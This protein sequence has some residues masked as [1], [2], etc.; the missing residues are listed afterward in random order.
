MRKYLEEKN[1]PLV[2]VIVPIYNTEK[3]LSDCVESLLQQTY[4][5][6]EIILVDDGSKDSSGAICDQYSSI[7]PIVKVIHT[8]NQGRTRARITGVEQ[9]S[10]EYVT[11]VDAD[12]FVAPTYVE[13]LTSCLIEQN[14]EI[15]CCECY[16]IIN[17]QKSLFSRTE[18]GRFD[19]YGIERLLTNS[20][21]YDNRSG[22]ASIPLFLWGKLIKKDVVHQSLPIGEDLWYGEDIATIFY[23]LQRTNSL[24]I[25]K[26]AHYFYRQHD[27]QT[28]KQIE[29]S[30][31]DNNIRLFQTL[32]AIDQDN[33]LE[34]QL[35]LRI[36][37]ELRDW[38]KGRH[39]VSNSYSEFKFDMAYALSNETM[40]KY[41][42]HKRI[43]TANKR[44]RILAFFAQHKMYYLYYIFL[45]AHLV[46][47]RTKG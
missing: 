1:S 46:I 15:S 32:S 17:G 21:L 28:I 7:N 25:S 35:P 36:L 10:G 9:A 19:R 12:D 30:R 13:Y 44:H 29:K 16:H 34:E 11:F 40:E 4:K 27:D 39:L 33:Y 8:H 18:S 41:F 47:L 43:I 3:Y 24:Y 23:I 45:K 20:F 31:W 38:L 26:E 37:S 14:V 42:M 2:S 6:L 5:P 22:V